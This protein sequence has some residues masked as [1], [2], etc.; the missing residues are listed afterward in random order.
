MRVIRKHLANY[1]QMIL[2]FIATSSLCFCEKTSEKP[3]KVVKNSSEASK[4]IPF[5]GWAVT[6]AIDKSSFA[7]DATL[8]I[9]IHNHEDLASVELHQTSEDEHKSDSRLQGVHSEEFRVNIPQ[10]SEPV[11]VETERL[12]IDRPFHVKILGLN[13]DGC[14][15]NELEFQGTLTEGRSTFTGKPQQKV[16]GFVT[17]KTLKLSN[18]YWKVEP[19]FCVEAASVTEELNLDSQ[20]Q[21]SSEVELILNFEQGMFSPQGEL[22]LELKN[23]RKQVKK[24][25]KK[26]V[27][28]GHTWFLKTR[29]LRQGEHY[30]I[31]LYAPGVEKCALLDASWGGTVEGQVI[32]VFDLA[33]KNRPDRCD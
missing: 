14:S 9:V 29:H 2:I 12:T 27:E 25:S 10:G 17:N 18:F 7:S 30:S 15:M 1:A 23:Q 11:L 8:Q 4:K 19:V 33:W 20:L 26:V 31:Y 22:T 5:S 13:S 16:L 24:Y 28:V 21:Q 6:F 32:E 3:Q